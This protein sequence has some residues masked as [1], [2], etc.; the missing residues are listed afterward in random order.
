MITSKNVIRH[1]LIGLSVVVMK[2]SNPRHRGIS[3][4][5][6]DETKNVVTICTVSGNKIIPKYLTTFR[7]IL[8]DNT[9][10]DVD[11]SVLVMQPE[12]RITL[13]TK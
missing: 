4:T 10:V 5:I 3:G 9:I 12:K 11:G 8:P 13:R 2:A 7:F 1:E 6:I